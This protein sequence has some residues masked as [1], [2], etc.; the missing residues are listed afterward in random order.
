MYIRIPIEIRGA[1]FNPCWGSGSRVGSR[2][3]ACSVRT[4][5]QSPYEEAG[6]RIES[7]M[8][9]RIPSEAPGPGLEFRHRMAHVH[10]NPNRDT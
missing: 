7:R 9:V 2:I 10:P 3:L 4:E 8:E 5:S 1:A 6:A